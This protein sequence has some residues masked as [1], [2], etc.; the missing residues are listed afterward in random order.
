[1]GATKLIFSHPRSGMFQ[2]TLPRRERRSAI[3]ALKIVS[4]VSI[5]AP[6]KGATVPCDYHLPEYEV[7]IHAPAKGAT[8]AIGKPT[9]CTICFNP[10]SREGS[11]D[12]RGGVSVGAAVSIHA[13]AKGATFTVAKKAYF[14]VVSIHAPA[15]G[16]TRA[17]ECCERSPRFQSTL[18][19]RER[20]YYRG[21]SSRSLL[22][23]IHAP[24]KGATVFSASLFGFPV[25]VSIHA[26]A[27]GATLYTTINAI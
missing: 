24:A 1:M 6:A 17:V 9:L 3:A 12:R 18:P 27:K 26:P 10:R 14:A 13:P 2:S 15:K 20:R 19:R 5:H 22:V 21:I 4:N 7:S 11:D 8:I 23:S 16:A 25:Q